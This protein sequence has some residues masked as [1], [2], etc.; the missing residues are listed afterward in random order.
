MVVEKP[1]VH[2]TV[3]LDVSGSGGFGWRS[4]VGAMARHFSLKKGTQKKATND[5]TDDGNAG[6]GE[7]EFDQ[8]KRDGANK[9]IPRKLIRFVAKVWKHVFLRCRAV[10]HILTAMVEIGEEGQFQ[11]FR[12]GR[13]DVLAAEWDEVY[14]CHK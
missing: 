3:Y 14:F 7:W 10:E 8:T 13:Q 4:K 6:F 2:E 11:I 5:I 1:T 9:K 12:F